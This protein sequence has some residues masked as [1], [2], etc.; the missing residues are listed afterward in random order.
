MSDK[1]IEELAK[2]FQN[3][4]ALSQFARSYDLDFP[5]D[6][7]DLLFS[8]LLSEP[9]KNLW[10]LRGLAAN[11]R[12][13]LGCLE[14]CIYSPI[15]T[16]LFAIQNPRVDELTGSKELPIHQIESVR[17]A[18][19]Q[20]EFYQSL[21]AES[22]ASDTSQERFAE[23]AA[24]NLTSSAYIAFW[25]DRESAESRREDL[26][27]GSDPD[28]VTLSA[29]AEAVLE[30]FVDLDTSPEFPELLWRV[31]A[32]RNCETFLTRQVSSLDDDFQF[33]NLYDLLELLPA[34]LALVIAG[35][36]ENYDES[37]PMP[38]LQYSTFSV[39]LENSLKMAH[40]STSDSDRISTINDLIESTT[41]DPDQ[42]DLE[43]DWITLLSAI[44]YTQ[45]TELLESIAQGD[46]DL[47]KLAVAL[48]PSTTPEIVEL[49]DNFECDFSLEDLSELDFFEEMIEYAIQTQDLDAAKHWQSLAGVSENE[50]A[51]DEDFE[52]DDFDDEEDN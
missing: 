38:Q 10:A 26:F 2:S 43:S 16:H 47:W 27:Y 31:Q 3:F 24:L 19:G 14:Q 12:I 33:E 37:W 5:E 34:R 40:P 30:E 15:D 6:Q 17:N 22:S 52:D 39:D 36:A 49:A 8:Q 23:L 29:E 1:E 7:M 9:K 51:D 18:L 20:S 35:E 46:N 42:L 45:D 28:N 25:H 41:Y 4:D 13:S 11:Y 21:I 32:N 44:L 50:D 48:N